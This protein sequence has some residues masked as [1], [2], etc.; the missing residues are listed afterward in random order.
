MNRRLVGLALVGLALAGCGSSERIESAASSGPEPRR[1]EKLELPEADG[2]NHEVGTFG[3]QCER[4]VPTELGAPDP[5][6]SERV[7]DT[8]VDQDGEILPH[9]GTPIRIRF[10]R[11]WDDD[12]WSNSS[13]D[14]FTVTSD[15]SGGLDLA[16]VEVL[17]LPDA[18][19]R[20]LGNSPWDAR[21]EHLEVAKSYEAKAAAPVA[22]GRCLVVGHHTSGLFAALLSP[23]ETQD[24]LVA[25]GM[26]A[27][28]LGDD[29]SIEDVDPET[30]AVTLRVLN[31]VEHISAERAPV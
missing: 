19:L 17:T 27:G 18:D 11:G 26:F 3:E 5:D 12:S 23:T 2:P 24:T 29:R 15:Y 31:S 25:V 6:W 20:G 10:P 13:L 21:I 28:H 1:A 9:L 14:P 8:A 16:E 22:G 7:L 4:G 30:L